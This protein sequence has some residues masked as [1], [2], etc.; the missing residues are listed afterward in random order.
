LKGVYASWTKAL[1]LAGSGSFSAP[2]NQ[3]AVLPGFSWQVT[4]VPLSVAVGNNEPFGGGNSMQDIYGSAAS[5][6]N[7]NI[8]INPNNVSSGSPIPHSTLLTIKF[9]A[10]TP[11]SGWG[12]AVVDLDVDQVRFRAKD[13]SG[14]QVPLNT[15]AGWFVQR[16]DADPTTD[17]VNLPSWDD[18]MVAVIGSESSSTTWRDTVEGG[19]D[20]NE[21]GAAWFQPNTSLSEISFEYESLQESANPSYHVFLAACAA[22]IVSPTPT[23]TPSGNQDSDGDTIPDATEGTTDPDDDQVPNYLDKDS[24]NDTIPDSSEGTG[25]PDGDGKPDYVDRDSDGDDVSDQIERDPDATTD[26]STGKD[27]NR[28]GIDDGDE[29]KTDEPADDSDGDS[30]PNHLDQDSDN[31][32]EDDGEEAYDLDGDGS[33][34]V[35]SSSQDNDD[36]G[37]DDAFEDFDSPQEINQRFSGETNKPVCRSVSTKKTKRGVRT[38]LF[39]LANRVP[40]FSKRTLACGG[41]IPNNL[42]SSAETILRGMERRLN[43]N[44]PDKGLVCPISVCAAAPSSQARAALQSQAKQLYRHAKK[45]KLLAIEACGSPANHSGQRRPSTETYHAQLRSEISKLPRKLSTCAGS[46]RARYTR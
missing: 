3:V 5:A 9:D 23:P 17:G 22:S 33:R 10:N 43:A 34:D 1:P 38:R 8:R 29:E 15:L 19:L 30:V 46:T 14:A 25:D 41:D 21:A 32:G 6:T 28:D 2:A 27:E 24:D 20:D 18:Q 44:F 7:L 35:T 40:M 11:A 37:L 16:F 42:G 36:N 39:A 13:A 12:F 31:D 26:T 4:G 45:A